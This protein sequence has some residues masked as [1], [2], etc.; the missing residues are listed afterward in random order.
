[1]QR[2]GFKAQKGTRQQY[3]DQ[4]LGYSFLDQTTRVPTPLK[5][6]QV[7][8]FIAVTFLTYCPGYE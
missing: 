3:D 1:M 6:G 7:W 4:W 8:A 5:I 2:A